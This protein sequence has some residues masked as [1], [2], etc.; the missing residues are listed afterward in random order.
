[1][2]TSASNGRIKYIDN[3]M[4]KAKFRR[5]EGKFVAEGIKMFNEAPK[6]DVLEVYIKEG[7]YDSFDSETKKKLERIGYE[8]LSEPVFKKVTDTVTPQGIL[9]VIK[10]RES[11]FEDILSDENPIIAVLENIQDPGNIGTIIRTAE[12]AGVNGLLLSR[13]CVDIFNP[14]VIRSTMGSVFRMKFAY[15]DIDS[16]FDSFRSKNIETYALVLDKKAKAYDKYDYKKSVAFFVGNEGN[17]LKE[18]TIEKCGNT[19]FIPMCGEVESLN[20]SVAAS[21]MM[22]EIF[23]Q[24]RQ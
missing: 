2:I 13:D 24:R 16:V 14:K 9:S 7:A 15:V 6:G 3:L 10:I 20:A 1:M 12:G 8:V 5:S 21:L 17:G 23:R 22:Y 19:A 11:S 4:Q 18:S